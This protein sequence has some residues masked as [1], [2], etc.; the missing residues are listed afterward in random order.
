MR[1]ILLGAPGSGKGTQAKILMEKYHIPQIST[2]DLLRAAVAAKTT[3][4]LEAKAIME[5]G[6]LVPDHLVLSIIQ[7]RLSEP[8]TQNGFILDGFPRNL[9]QAQALEPILKQI[10]QPLDAAILIDVPEEELIRRT[11]GRLTCKQCKAVFNI[12]TNPP[13]QEGICDIC[14]SKAL[15]HRADDNEETVRNRLNV[16]SQQTMPLIEYYEK[17]SHVIKIQGDQDIHKI[18][19]EIITALAPYLSS[20]QH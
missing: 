11:A 13:K 12:Y 18:T 15:E 6:G 1:I 2:G 14:G 7:E 19:E 10:N 17:H 5:A 20:S 16:Y 9:T 8:D 3:L 4:G